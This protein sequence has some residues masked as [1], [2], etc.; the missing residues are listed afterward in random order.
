MSV[1]TFIGILEIVDWTIM[2]V[3]CAILVIKEKNP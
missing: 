2:S 3:I 1:E